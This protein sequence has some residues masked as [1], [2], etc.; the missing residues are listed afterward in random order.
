VRFVIVAR[1][2]IFDCFTWFVGG[3]DGRASVAHTRNM[4]GER[5][6]SADAAFAAAEARRQRI[7]AVVTEM[8]EV[9]AGRMRSEVGGRATT[10]AD[11]TALVN[12]GAL[13]VE[14]KGRKVLYRLA[15]PATR[16]ENLARP[17]D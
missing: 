6:E 3:I 4:G 13:T 9:S 11:L 12:D 5:R 14:R 7:L 17:P 8:G 15:T 16:S 10:Y 2:V 1:K